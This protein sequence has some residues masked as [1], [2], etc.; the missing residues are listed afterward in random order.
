MTLN[1][2]E[3]FAISGAESYPTFRDFYERYIH[4]GAMDESQKAINGAAIHTIRQELV[5]YSVT[6]ST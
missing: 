4:G 3:L 2:Y 5:K 6:A 1:K